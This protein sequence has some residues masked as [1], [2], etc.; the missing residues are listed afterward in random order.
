M[1]ELLPMILMR[2][3]GTL[4]LIHRFDLVCWENLVV[5]EV[6]V[7]NCNSATSDEQKLKRKKV[8]KRTNSEPVSDR[9]VV[10]H[11]ILLVAVK[12]FAIQQTEF[13]FS[14]QIAVTE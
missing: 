10:A 7:F 3:N 11:H 6:P 2:K 4:T 5:K 9:S 12:R 13:N 14:H 8:L 1:L